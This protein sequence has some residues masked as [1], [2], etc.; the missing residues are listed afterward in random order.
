MKYYIKI[1]KKTNMNRQYKH[2]VIQISLYQAPKHSNKK[3]KRV[4]Y[5]KLRFARLANW[6]GFQ[7]KDDVE[8]SDDRPFNQ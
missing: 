1:L 3:C 2:V 6:I 8:R 5:L 4:K 7:K